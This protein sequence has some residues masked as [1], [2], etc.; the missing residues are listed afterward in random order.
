MLAAGL[1]CLGARRLT[2]RRRRLLHVVRARCAGL[3]RKNNIAMH[4]CGHMRH[5]VGKLTEDESSHEEED[6]GPILESTMTHGLRLAFRPWARN[7]M[8]L[9]ALPDSKPCAISCQL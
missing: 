5:R 8:A 3:F 7:P 9:P 2:V 6:H 4:R 1:R